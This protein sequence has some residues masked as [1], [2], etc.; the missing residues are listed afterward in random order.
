MS[1]VTYW[2]QKRALDN[3]ELELQSLQETVWVC[4]CHLSRTYGKRSFGGI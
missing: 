4:V 2:G 3:L 1:V